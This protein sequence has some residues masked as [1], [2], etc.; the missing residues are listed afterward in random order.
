MI[1][2]FERLC[3]V[4]MWLGIG[5][6]ASTFITW[7]ILS[8]P[9]FPSAVNFAYHTALIFVWISIGLAWISFGLRLWNKRKK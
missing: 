4:M 9:H 2:W 6:L 3:I 8:D 5:I 7:K 1:K